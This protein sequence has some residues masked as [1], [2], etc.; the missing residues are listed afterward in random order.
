MDPSEGSRRRWVTTGVAFVATLGLS[1]LFFGRLPVLYD[2]DSYYHL[3]I[4]RAYAHFGIV[5]TLPWARLSLLHDFADK[6]FLFHL[7]LAPFAAGEDPA[8]G[9]RLALA[10]WNAIIV[11]LLVHLGQRVA[12][13]WGPWVAVLAYAGSLPFLGRMIRL[14]PELLALVLIL[15]AVECVGARRY[16]TLG[17]VALAFTLGYTA[18]HALLGLCGLWFLHHRWT[19]G[20]WEWPLA[21]YP[22]LGCGLG[23]ILHPHFPQNLVVWKVQSFDFFVGKG[24]LNV[25][26]EIL[27][28]TTADLLTQNLGWWVALVVLALIAVRSWRSSENA[29]ASS[30]GDEPL[31]S[32]LTVN[33]ALTVDALWVAAVVF[34]GLY[35]LM[36]RFATYAIPLL[37]LA[38]LG[39]AYR[40]ST[41]FDFKL[42]VALTVALLL[43]AVPT[44]QLL[45]GISESGGPV[46]REDEWRAFGQSVPAGARVAAEWGSTHIYMF[47]APQGLYLNVL[48]PI[49]MARPYPEAYGA[50]R[51]IFENRESDIPLTLAR[52][53]A[54]DHLA[55]SHFHQPQE[56]LLR[57]AG[58]PRLESVY[59][60]YTL[61]Y[62]LAPEARAPFVVDWRVVPPGARLPPAPDTWDTLSPYP[63]E[64]DAEWRALE[65][66]VD[67]R[68]VTDEPEPCLAVT[69]RM[70]VETPRTEIY[71]LAAEGPTRLWHDDTLLFANEDSP[72][73]ILGRGVMFPVELTSGSHRFTVLT[74]PHR[75]DPE[76]LGFYLLSRAGSE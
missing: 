12:G 39:E 34:G 18:F 26:R 46:S 45:R 76:R 59:R 17:A 13:P 36:Q 10:L 41:R 32:A 37:L 67:G 43:G 61:L 1:A 55:L 58:D 28:Q 27:P 30:P 24:T 54:S 66:F 47:W 71:E 21:L 63:L 49:F 31:S 52:D 68:R 65:G 74:C 15:L 35:L 50:L 56:L 5:D 33:S 3:A 51:G 2:T 9:G 23:L 8:A 44:V 60:G 16:R 48:D 62:R 72:G 6:E 42:S 19:H 11:A 57:L 53:L 14:R 4:A 7:L 64:E 22:T 75:E 38:I 20:R 69:H 40:R 70:E 29:E 25:G 73:A